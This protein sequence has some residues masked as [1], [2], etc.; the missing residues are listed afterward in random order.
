M[1]FRVDRSAKL[2]MHKGILTLTNQINLDLTT[3]IKGPK[4][5]I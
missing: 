1:E 4:G 3:Q 2:N 5:N